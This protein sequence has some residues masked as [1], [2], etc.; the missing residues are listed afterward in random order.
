[1]VSENAYANF[2]QPPNDAEPLPNGCTEVTEWQEVPVCCAFGYVYDGA[3]RHPINKVQVHIESQDGQLTTSTR[4]D[5]DGS[6]P[7][8]SVNLSS[9]P[10]WVEPG[11]QITVT[12]SYSDRT[13]SKLYTVVGGGQQIDL[14]VPSEQ[15]NLAPIATIHYIHPNAATSY[16]DSMRF[17]GSAAD[18]DAINHEGHAEI[19]EQRWE[20]DRDGLLDTRGFFTKTVASLSAGVHTIS[21]Q[22]KDNENSWSTPVSRPFSK[23]I[24]DLNAGW[25]V[26]SLAAPP[27]A[28]YSSSD[29]MDDLMDL[30]GC[31][32]AVASWQHDNWKTALLNP[33]IGVLTLAAQT[34]YFVET[35]C[36]STATLVSVNKP[37]QSASIPLQP[38]WNFVALAHTAPS[39]NASTA[40]TQIANQG[41]RVMQIARWHRHIS[42]W[43]THICD[44][45][46]GDFTMMPNGN[47]FLLSEVESIWTPQAAVGAS[48]QDT[49]RQEQDRQEQ[50]LTASSAL[51]TCQP[52]ISN[53]RI[54]NLRARSASISW[55]TGFDSDGQVR[56]GTDAAA[57]TQTATDDRGTAIES[58]IH[59]ITIGDLS[60]ETTY[61]FH[62]QSGNTT[63][64][65]DGVAYQFTT[66]PV[67]SI[68]SND[69]IWG[70]VVQ[71]DD[72]LPFANALVYLTIHDND[73]TGNGQSA[74]LSG[75]TDANGLWQLAGGGVINLGAARTQ[76]G[77]RYFDYS[78]QGDQLALEAIARPG[79]TTTRQIDTGADSPATQLTIDCSSGPTPCRL[80]VTIQ[81][82]IEN[83]TLFPD[84]VND[85]SMAVGDLTNDGTQ[86]LVLTKGVDARVAVFQNPGGV[87]DEGTLLDGPS[88][89]SAERP[90]IAPI[91]NDGQNWLV[92]DE[93]RFGNTGE[94]LRSHRYEGTKLVENMDIDVAQ[95][96][97]GRYASAVADLDGDGNLEIWVISKHGDF[98]DPTNHLRRYVWDAATEQY[99]Y[100]ELKDGGVNF[101][102]MLRPVADDFLGNGSESLIWAGR[103]RELDLVT[104]TAGAG[105]H[106][107]TSQVIV[108]PTKTIHGFDAGE[109]DGLPGADIAIS[110]WD[111][112]EAEIVL[113]TGITFTATEIITG[114]NEWLRVVRVA[115]LDSDGRAEIYAAGQDG[116]IYAY[117]IAGGM[118]LLDL[119]PDV[120][121]MDGA[122]V[123]W[124]DTTHNEVLFAGPVL[125]AEGFT[126]RTFRVV[127]LRAQIIDRNDP[128]V[129]DPYDPPNNNE[130]AT[131]R[132]SPNVSDIDNDVL[133]Y[134]WT[135]DS[136]QCTLS[137]PTSLPTDITCNDNGHYVATLTV[138]DGISDPVSRAIPVIINNVA[139]NVEMPRADSVTADACSVVTATATFT[140]PGANDGPF[141]C[142]VDYGD[143]TGRVPG[144]ME[145]NSCVSPTHR[146]TAAGSYDI[147]FSV[148][149]KDGDMGTSEA[150]IF[151]HEG[152]DSATYLPFVVR[153]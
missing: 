34:P 91:R 38:G 23:M 73:S 70:Q 149:D 115:D 11:E 48:L 52:K 55:L 76:D 107:H 124:A 63:D 105:I 148:T 134:T 90:L 146:Y 16:P 36:P 110:T 113:V 114:V 57:L 33:P 42:N 152:C 99:P 39:L 151:E 122:V 150:L 75:L 6:N 3:T 24:Y 66:G 30:G 119:Q 32:R 100:V 13:A 68:P 54:T 108:R 56:Y 112:S 141:T 139:P 80:D 74:P 9:E 153:P 58:T 98:P 84:D 92:Y 132:L 10:L 78:P 43:R 72:N 53:V 51:A 81:T 85:L 22:I 47:Y 88:I 35:T 65:N 128:P 126:D 49:K 15:E 12:T 131:I 8:F 121:W 25:N 83:D 143:E 125:N 145:G 59:H 71:V 129:V 50:S 14:V 95:I 86:D 79:C 46:I 93:H 19:M 103:Q 31:P 21:Y 117:D 94:W 60:P 29:F 2:I 133:T 27:R 138:S 62:V 18:G 82:I 96:W 130:G 101:E 106:N 26:V 120:R 136:D 147:I 102:P 127:S 28:N 104:Y 67:L 37:A 61:Y 97:P 41:G 4:A 64:D 7:Y 69:A 144:T 87:W 111:G 5:T 20:S 123:R 77:T 135:I 1:M 118:R 45:S 109:I 17:S 40:C 137:D 140:D 116:G 44:P 89:T 142:M